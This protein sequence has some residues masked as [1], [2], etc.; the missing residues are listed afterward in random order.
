[1]SRAGAPTRGRSPL[2]FAERERQ[3]RPGAEARRRSGRAIPEHFV[4]IAGRG[5]KVMWRRYWRT[6]GETARAWQ[7]D[8]AFRMAAAL[9][10][11]S[12][13]SMIPLLL[14]AIGVTS[15]VV[16]EGVAR[17]EVLAQL[18]KFVGDKPGQAV[19]DVLR[20]AQETGTYPLFTAVGF[21]VLVVGSSWVLLELQASLGTTWQT[22]ARPRG[23]WFARI[24]AWILSLAAVIATGLLVL[25]MLLAS[26]LL[27]LLTREAELGLAHSWLPHAVNGVLSVGLVV[28]LFA[29]LYKVLP[30]APVR[31][32][33]VWAGAFTAALLYE[34]G[35]YAVSI[36]LDYF[37]LGS[38][39]GAA[40][41]LVV[42][43]MW[44]YYSSLIFFFGAELT[45]V[46][47]RQAA[48]SPG[49]R[50]GDRQGAS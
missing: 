32:R 39:F 18:R 37:F 27:T 9:A 43:L 48:A 13:F 14:I 26:M 5:S 34:V 36:Y 20:D 33:E 16:G 42:V 7:Q 45:K 24:Y 35:K 2:A 6:L 19:E 1:M 23:S 17:G 46:F 3:L 29:V 8:N 11:Y 47:A 22:G 10:Y 25:G 15:L 41:S 38:A 28:L 44:V 12:V 50:A 4:A 30:R 21:V 31:W 49:D 40:S